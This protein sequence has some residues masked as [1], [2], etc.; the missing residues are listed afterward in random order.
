MK[1]CLLE[2]NEN[3]IFQLTFNRPEVHNAFNEEMIAELID[4]FGQLKETNECRCLVVKANGPSFCAGADLNW[5][6]K[7]KDYGEEKNIQDAKALCQLFLQL[8]SLPMPTVGL[9]RGNALGGGVGIVSCLD[10]V[11]SSPE[12]EFGLTE[13]RL[14]LIP[15]VISPFVMSKIGETHARA[16]FSTGL[17]FNAN[18]A[19]QMGLIHQISSANEFDQTAQKIISQISQTAPLASKMAK[20]LAFKI[21]ELKR[22]GQDDSSIHE[23]TYKTIA[24]VRT[25]KEA[26]E[27]MSSLL[28]KRKPNWPL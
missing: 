23:Y 8:N 11:L 19:K 2:K 18:D 16:Y 4:L 17:R 21:S 9:I 22:S 24:K 25:G 12:V 28:E 5:M 6:K 15:A 26:Q 1:F 20:A 13:V 3:N 27:G 14:G 7:M 10:F